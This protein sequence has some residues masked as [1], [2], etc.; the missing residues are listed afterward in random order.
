MDEAAGVQDV[1]L[2]SICELW[3]ADAVQPGEH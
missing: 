1:L 2:H 3:H